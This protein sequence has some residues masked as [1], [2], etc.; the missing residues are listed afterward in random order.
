MNAPS[1]LARLYPAGEPPF[2]HVDRL[3]FEVLAQ[4][5]LY[6]LT[7]NAYDWGSRGPP[8]FRRFPRLSVSPACSADPMIFSHV[9]SFWRAV[10]IQT[11]DLWTKL[12]IYG[13]RWK[14]VP[15]IETWIQ[16][17]NNKP[18]SFTF[19]ECLDGFLVDGDAY[20]A[21][22]P[23]PNTN[24]I[25]QA[26]I[27]H[28]HRW[29]SVEFRF[30][31]RIP[32]ALMDMPHN[33]LPILEKA[34]ISSRDNISLPC[35]PSA[36]MPPL[37]K[38]WKAFHSAPNLKSAEYEVDYME[39]PIREINMTSL[40]SIDMMLTVESFF[41]ILPQC[42][43]LET[44]QY[45]D[46]RARFHDSHL[47]GK[48]K[49]SYPPL[50]DPEKPVILPRLKNL[51]MVTENP[52]DEVFERLTLPSLTSLHVEQQRAWYRPPKA[53][54]FFDFLVRSECNLETYHVNIAG[55][56]ETDKILIEIISSPHLS[57]VKHL[58]IDLPV[59]DDVI[60]ALTRN[61]ES[62]GTNNLSTLP[63]LEKL[64]LRKCITS[65]GKLL[66]MARSRRADFGREELALLDDLL[67]MR[68]P[69]P[70][71]VDKEGLEALAA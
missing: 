8:T 67:V 46:A 13:T 28:S 15:V 10:A 56:P 23:N 19:F 7:N 9:S 42:M 18:I 6:A 61:S 26:L 32:E 16:R 41:E 53:A 40:T 62:S 30:A 59:C 65:G 14:Q 5:F 20:K 44:I 60:G 71:A 58:S 1:A 37:L 68:W 52:A 66:E 12:S 33:R 45:T 38:V 25:V 70:H 35:S 34:A 24:E 29:K 43:H 57:K 55:R 54:P 48:L 4:I 36:A 50:P 11:S 21:Y 49:R 51:H 22:D 3:P 27:Q 69:E 47:N 64:V 39:S 17:A 63:R 31:R 2:G